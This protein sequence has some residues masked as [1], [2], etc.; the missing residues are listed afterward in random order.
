MVARLLRKYTT[1]KF[2][3]SYA[4][5]ARGHRGVVY[6]A[7]GWTYVGLSSAMSLYSVRG[8]KPQH[9]RSL[10]HRMGSHSVEFLRSR[11]LDIERVPQRP[12]HRYVLFLDPSWAAL[13]AIQPQPYP[14][15]P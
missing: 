12:K 8:G 15:E 9:S 14:K 1:I 10:S 3:V 13:L 4:D 2:L 5:L 7:A 11:G 6:Q